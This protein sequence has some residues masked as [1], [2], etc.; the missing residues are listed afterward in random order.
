ML[1]MM[2]IDALSISARPRSRI[3]IAC[4]GLLYFSLLIAGSNFG[5]PRV[6]SVPSGAGW[7]SVTSTSAP[8]SRY[9]PSITYD[10]R[11][12]R[13][14]L[15]GGSLGLSYLSDTWSYD[16]STNTWTN[17][18]P[19]SG[20]S[21]R[22]G[23]GMAYDS[24][25][26]KI[27]LFGG[28]TGS[29]Y[30]GET[31]AYDYST[32]TWTLKLTPSI[33]TPPPQSLNSNGMVFDSGANSVYL[34]DNSGYTWYYRYSTN[35]W[36]YVPTS[37]RPPARNFPT[38]SYD[39]QSDRIILFGGS[40]FGGSSSTVYDDTWV[41]FWFSNTWTNVTSTVKPLARYDASMAWDSNSDKTILFGGA[42]SPSATTA[43]TWAFDYTTSSWSNRVP[44][45]SPPAQA[46][47]GMAYNSKL[48]KIILFG[49][50]GMWVYGT[51]ST[52]TTVGCAPSASVNQAVNC[53]ATIA[54]SSSGAAISPTGT[55][56]LSAIGTGTLS[57]PSC[58]LNVGTSSSSCQF[59]YTPTAIGTGSHSISAYYSGDGSHDQS[60]GAATVIVTPRTTSATLACEP[61]SVAIGQATTCTVSV[62]DTSP[63]SIISPSGRVDFPSV[64]TGTFAPNFCSL[65]GTTVT[66]TCQVQYTPTSF[67]Q[68]S[69]AIGE[70]Y[71]GDINHS[72]NQAS[73]TVTVGKRVSAITVSCF[74]ASVVANQVSLC[75]ASVNDTS[76]GSQVTATGSVTFSS[77]GSGTFSS[78][79]CSLASTSPPATCQVIYDPLPGG[80]SV[81]Q[82]KGSYNGD[83]AHLSSTSPPFS[84]G[85]ASNAPQQSSF[86]ASVR[87]NVLA[88]VVVAVV[89][90]FGAAVLLTRRAKKPD[91]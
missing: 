67:G 11:V 91:V 28:Y 17:M 27:I 74:P 83:A 45:A 84:L 48:D 15:F 54:D 81:D 69:H 30:S 18:N 43:D 7:F 55:A 40:A 80:K 32:N 35:S 59:S 57:A 62:T 4:L 10:S 53:T 6:G 76:S 8:S 71:A 46:N 12:D 72:T 19:A 61:T 87:S 90:G 85:I 37:A 79:S 66:T 70:N 47:A 13:V 64:N 68:G 56:T 2:L 82:I 88:L 21:A 5:L 63:G 44:S 31:W 3:R 29:A 22:Y 14:I 86:L 65:S 78:T 52:T 9:V 20:P 75:T 38:L 16:Y 49:G 89:I 58:A 1:K 73:A 51:R 34:Q 42:L 60:S 25:D 50:T 23:A 24:T 33:T 39:S 41:Y 36:T 26:D 77:D